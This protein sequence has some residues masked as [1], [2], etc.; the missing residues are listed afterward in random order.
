LSVPEKPVKAYVI[1]MMDYFTQQI[2]YYVGQA[3]CCSGKGL[4]ASLDLSF[5]VSAY[6]TIENGQ[7]FESESVHLLSRV[8]VQHIHSSAAHPASNGAVERVV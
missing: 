3:C 5:F 7:E 6:V 4:L 1:I 8:G 2:C